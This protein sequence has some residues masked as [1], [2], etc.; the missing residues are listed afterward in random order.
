MPTAPMAAH[1][2][3]SV[4]SFVMSIREDNVPLLS[5]YDGADV[6]RCLFPAHRVIVLSIT[7]RS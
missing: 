5:P 1:T 4:L 2:I 6:I 3:D 7:N